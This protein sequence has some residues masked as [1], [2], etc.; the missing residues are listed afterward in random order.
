MS[1]TV[2]LRSI[3]CGAEAGRKNAAFCAAGDLVGNLVVDVCTVAAAAERMTEVS[4]AVT[5]GKAAAVT[6]VYSP[7][8]HFARGS[9]LP[10]GHTEKFHHVGAWIQR[11][12]SCTSVWSS[13]RFL[14]QIHP[15][16]WIRDAKLEI[17]PQA[18]FYNRPDNHL[19]ARQIFAAVWPELS[20]WSGRSNKGIRQFKVSASLVK[21]RPKQQAVLQSAVAQV[22][23]PA[24]ATSL[25]DHL[26]EPGPGLDGPTVSQIWA[27]LRAR[28]TLEG[29]A[30]SVHL[31][32][33]WKGSQ[34][35]LT[36]SWIWIFTCL[37]GTF[38]GK[39][40]ICCD[41]VLLF[42]SGECM[43]W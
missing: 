1:S 37:L 18:K 24:F 28:E 29:R 23:H 22:G 5:A 27:I 8:K 19:R 16:N 7:S 43:C 15:A 35:Y 4:F 21:F 32:L 2:I 3:S 12:M 13:Y 26:R 41:R 20:H 33:Y 14:R 39:K 42:R 9:S 11:T 25:H 30:S 40:S 10:R 17:T 6:K 34:S 31:R 38:C 36:M